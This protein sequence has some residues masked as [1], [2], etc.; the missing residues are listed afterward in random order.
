MWLK[1][2]PGDRRFEPILLPAPFWDLPPVS[3]AHF[4]FQSWCGKLGSQLQRVSHMNYLGWVDGLLVGSLEHAQRLARDFLRLSATR[5]AQA[6]QMCHPR[7]WQTFQSR[8]SFE[9]DPV[10]R[11]CPSPPQTRG[12]C[13]SE[14]KE[15][16]RCCIERGEHA[17]TGGRFPPV[18]LW[19]SLRRASTRCASLPASRRHARPRQ[20]ASGGCGPDWL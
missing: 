10:R 19:T 7:W 1:I 5:S 14:R 12:A 13:A 3:H 4:S 8:G 9:R 15:T 20:R 11:Q 6:P 17:M 2:E 18:S 16:R